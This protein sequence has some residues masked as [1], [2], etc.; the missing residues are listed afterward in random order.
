MEGDRHKR[1][2]GTIGQRR[3]AFI[4]LRHVGWRAVNQ[5]QSLSGKIRE[6]QRKFDRFV[7]IVSRHKRYLKED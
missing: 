2:N 1:G 5:L 3:E 6:T 7:R 4:R